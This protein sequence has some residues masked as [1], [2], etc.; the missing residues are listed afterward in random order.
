MLKKIYKNLFGDPNDKVVKRYFQEVEESKKIE[1]EL[2]KRLTTIEKIQEKTREFQAKFEWLDCNNKEDYIL[3]KNILNSIK[4]EAI[5]VH[6]IACK[7][8]NGMEFDLWDHKFLWNMVPFDVQLV[9]ALALNDGNISEM[10]TWEWKT[11]VATIAA[12]LNALAGLPVHII[13]VNDY[14]AWR[15]AKEMWIIY[16]T[17]WLTVGVVIHSQ[18]PSEKKENYSRNIVY[19]TNN[20]LWFDYLRDNM[21]ISKDNRV[22]WP[23]Y[24][25]I[26]DEVDSILVDEARTPL[27][28]SAPDR[29]PTNKYIKFAQLAKILKEWTHYKIDE[30]WKTATL[31]EEWIREIEKMLGVENIYV[32]T[33]Y[34][35]IHHIENALKAQ[36]VYLKDVDYLVRNDEILIIDEH[37]WRVLSGRRYS[38]GLHQAIEAKESV[39]IQQESKTLASI[40]FQ[41]L[42][43]LYKKL[44]WMTGTAK[45]EEEEFIKIYNLQVMVIPTNKPMIREDRADALFKNEKW[46]FG[47][48]VKLIKEYNKVWQPV[49]VWTVSVAKSEYLSALLTEA[50]VPHEVLNAKQ[51]FREAEIISK[52]WQFWAVTIATNMA[53]RGTDIKID[54]KVKELSWAVNVWNQTYKLGWLVVIGTEKH[55]TRRIDNQLRWRSWRQWD[56]WLSQFMISPQ[57]DIMRIFWWEKLFSMFNSPMFSAIPDDEP[58][59]ELTYLTKRITSVQKQVEWR[60][61]DTRKHV[62]EYDD[63]LNHHRI[64]IYSRRNKILEQ[65]N[66]HEE[67]KIVI[68][69]Q[70]SVFINSIIDI[71]QLTKLEETWEIID[72]LNNYLESKLFSAESFEKFYT[73]KELI[74]YIIDIINN[75]IKELIEKFSEEKYYDFEKR[76]YLQSIDELWM[77]HID[78][79]AHLREE[80]AYEWYAQRNPLV[81]YQE[82]AYEK[83]IN[84]IDEIWFKMIKW[85]L[86]ANPE[87]KI[88]QTQ[89]N[90]KDL[91]MLLQE[92]W[93]N[94]EE[95]LNNIKNLISDEIY[96]KAQTEESWV[97]VYKV[98]NEQTQPKEEFP[99]V[100]RNES[101]PCGSGKKYKQCHWK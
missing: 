65:E 48:L 79:M 36:T 33:H 54:E 88:E 71:D 10:R 76:L 17:L 20:E 50:W 22:I 39:T 31:N 68:N 13:T 94:S 3:I 55:E 84:L 59:A 66:V 21:A 1:L 62:L 9:G 45:T 61:F 64:A 97:K 69:E 75:K 67:V 53:W 57:D 2:E 47:F 77:R 12:Y 7:L 92:S 8:I 23:L 98:N 24:Y 6:R 93:L 100:G 43:R 32:S 89:I 90:E 56:P 85:I 44:S 38:D 42:F 80:V 70:V 41:N 11:L 63:I 37:T 25:A 81:V 30:K 72:N 52:A 86:T 16:N 91:E 28:I 14:L 87:E 34:N 15:D 95:D 5:A 49:L 40:T 26:V 96:K 60:N 27:I 74:E 83:F 82:K 51:D 58:L 46:K 99:K 73:K 19:I 29:E 18:W 101:C 4:L 78:D 35:D